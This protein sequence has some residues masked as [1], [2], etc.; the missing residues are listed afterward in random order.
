MSNSDAPSKVH[1]LN[2]HIGLVAG[3]ASFIRSRLVDSLMNQQWEAVVLDNSHTGNMENV[4]QW[5]K[6]KRLG[7]AKDKLRNAADV[8]KAV[9]D[10]QTAFHFV[11]NPE[12]PFREA[13]LLLKEIAEKGKR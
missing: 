7:F 9:E 3:G 2:R 5:L 11:A 1:T 12:A 4:Q 10:S 8:Q 13:D 6:N